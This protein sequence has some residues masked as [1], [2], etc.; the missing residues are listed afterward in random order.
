MGSGRHICG[1]DRRITHANAYSDSYCYGHSNSDGDGH[2]NGHSYS[3]ANGYGD[4]Q[5]DTDSYGYSHATTNTYAEACAITQASPHAGT[6]TIEAL[7]RSQDF[8]D[9][10]QL[11][12]DR[13]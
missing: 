7:G 8:R 12:S 13:S 5:C 6:E 9:R 4:S 2:C 1:C 3:Y 11:T 10:R